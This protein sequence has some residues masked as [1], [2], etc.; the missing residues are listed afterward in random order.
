MLLIL[1]AYLTWSWHEDPDAI[2]NL[3]MFVLLATVLLV[4]MV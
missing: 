3:T 1:H 2:V 4:G